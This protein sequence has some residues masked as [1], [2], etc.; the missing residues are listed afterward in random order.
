MGLPVGTVRWARERSTVT[1][2]WATVFGVCFG[3]GLVCPVFVVELLEDVGL[4]T[5]LPSMRPSDRVSE[6]L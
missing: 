3:A 5:V 1:I 4:L 2:Q 6:V